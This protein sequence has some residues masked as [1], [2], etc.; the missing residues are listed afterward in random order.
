MSTVISETDA[1]LGDGSINNQVVFHNV[2][3]KGAKEVSPSSH[4]PPLKV[5]AVFTL[6]MLSALI[7]YVIRVLPSVAMEGA[8]GIAMELH[9]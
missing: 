8:N 5:A 4:V 3:E 2:D 9:W 1:L 6:A 7:C